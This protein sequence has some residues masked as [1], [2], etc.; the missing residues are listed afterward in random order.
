MQENSRTELKRELNDRFER[1]VASFLNYA[2]GGE[3]IIGVDDDGSAVGVANTDAEQLKIVDRIRNNIRPQTLGLFD[4]AQDKI[5]DK[6]I[7]RVIVSCGQRHPTISVNLECRSGA[8][9][10]EWAAHRDQ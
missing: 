2:G 7:I 5:E 3:I 1:S 10:F 9:L 8:A 6:D 4:V